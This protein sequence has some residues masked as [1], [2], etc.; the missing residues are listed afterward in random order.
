MHDCEDCNRIKYCKLKKEAELWDYN[1]VIKNQMNRDWNEMI[2]KEK[3][4][5]KD[6]T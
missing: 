2:L 1:E 4:N 3:Y 5:V 6:I